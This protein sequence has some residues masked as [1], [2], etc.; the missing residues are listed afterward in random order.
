LY[1]FPHGKLDLLKKVTFEVPIE[2]NGIYLTYITPCQNPFS[3][4]LYKPSTLIVHALQNK[5]QC[6]ET[7]C[8]WSQKPCNPVHHTCYDNF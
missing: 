5:T 7:D 1:K 4:R 6:S 2:K 3:Q 8:L